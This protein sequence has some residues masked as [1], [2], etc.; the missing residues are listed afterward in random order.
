MENYASYVEHNER[1]ILFFVDELFHKK[2][3]CGEVITIKDIG[4]LED[5]NIKHSGMFFC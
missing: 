4:K 3:K 5:I 1:S 2:T